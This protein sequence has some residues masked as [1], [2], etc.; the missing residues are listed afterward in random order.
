MLPLDNMAIFMLSCQSHTYRRI[1]SDYIAHALRTVKFT[2]LV[3]QNDTTTRS[4]ATLGDDQYTHADE[5]QGVS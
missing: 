1:H 2:S 3:E 4:A 5:G